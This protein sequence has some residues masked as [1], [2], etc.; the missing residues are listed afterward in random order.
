MKT[1]TRRKSVKD[2]LVENKLLS[3]DKLNAALEESKKLS[4]PLQQ[5]IVNLKLMDKDTLLRKLGEEWNLKAV[6]LAELEI[7]SETVKLVPENSAKRYQAVPFAKEENSLFLAMADPRDLFAIEDIHLRTGFE[8]IPYLAL[9]D[10]ISRTLEKSY[11]SGAVAEQALSKMLSSVGTDEN[12]DVTIEKAKEEEK[13]DI[14][15]VDASAPEVEK[16]VNV[17]ILGA[18][19][20]KASD[21][22]IEP[23]EKRVIVRYRVD[24]A[25]QETTFQTPF[26][27]RNAVI[28]KIKIMTSSMDITEHRRPQDGRIQL[29]AGGKPIEFRVNIVPTVF[30]ESVVMRILDRAS[31]KVD[32]DKMGFLPDTL[33][34]LKVAASK[35]YGITLVCGPTGSGKSTTLYSL[36]N[37]INEPDTKILTAE[38][39]VEYNLEGI[40]QVPTNKEIGFDFS[41]ALRAFL[42][43]DPDVIML[44]EIRDEETAITAMEAAM[45]G[46]LVFSTVHT[47]DSPST[48]ARLHEMG[49]PS[50]MISSSIEAILAQRLLRRVCSECKEQIQPGPQHDAIFKMFNLDT[51]KMN[52]QKGKGCSTCNGTG[53]KGRCGIHEL[54][55]MT[56]ELRTLMLKEYASGPI[57]DLA[58]KQGMRLMVADALIKVI[59][60]VTTLEEVLNTCNINFAT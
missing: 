4:I 39:P 34:K 45:T 22:H 18:L 20:K 32:L 9:S 24:G 43:Q 12:S 8:I 21:I 15:D 29:V 23:F 57:R 60:G 3:E 7:D 16:L 52:L 41:A 46:H 42:R 36:L 13:S 56:D 6:D 19:Q 11:G 53:Y 35:P 47:N 50:F 5:A 58:V 44:G 2:I 30:G 55:I 25:L 28:A 49:V 33:E 27:Y 1:A 17:I 38:N 37:W 54:L 40:V 14:T 31:I 59:N 51:S 10:D 26:A 48:I